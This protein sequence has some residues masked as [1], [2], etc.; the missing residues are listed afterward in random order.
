VDYTLNLNVSNV[1]ATGVT[2]TDTMPVDMTFEGIIPTNP[3]PI[4]TVQM[5][6][7]PTP[8][9]TPGSGE[10]LVWTF[11][12]LPI[13][14]YHLSY[15]AMVNAFV[16][17]GTVLWNTGELTYEENP[18]PQF[19]SVPITVTGLYTLYINV[20]NESGELVKT[21]LLKNVSEPINNAS[22]KVNG[23][24]NSLTESVD[25]YDGSTLITVWNGTNNQNQPVS[26]GQYFLTIDNTDPF[27]VTSTVT[28]AITVDRTIDQTEVLI[29]NESGEVV[30]HLYTQL[31]DAGS[32]EVTT[33]QL[34]TN[35]LDPSNQSGTNDIAVTIEMKTGQANPEPLIIWNGTNDNG[36]LV[37]NGQYFI[38]VVTTDGSGSTVVVT[39]AITVLAGNIVEDVYAAPNLIK[40]PN[41]P[42]VFYAK[43]PQALNLLVKIYDTDG[44]LVQRLDALPGN[45]EATWIP[46][47]VASGLYLAVVELRTDAGTII[48]QKIIKVVI[49]Q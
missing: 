25:V 49:L 29:Y 4:P 6:P 36:Q 44:E 30:R 1:M 47:G 41:E 20:Y 11:S 14:Q 27:G 16:F 24:I 38:Q 34:S 31:S 23:V 39:K 15:A 13:G 43:S 48:G 26:N 8:G 10:L 12:K 33:V 2:I 19:A 45:N 28:K 21:L 5:I 42:I 46:R 37:T 9:P 32:S 7:L 18:V 17:S 22:L 35:V 3:V 40:K